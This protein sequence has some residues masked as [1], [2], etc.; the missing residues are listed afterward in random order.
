VT[1]SSIA[2]SRTQTISPAAAS[3]PST[4][5]RAVVSIDA[6][7]YTPEMPRP[8][9]AG[10]FGIAR[11]TRSNPPSQRAMSAIRVPAAIEST[12]APDACSS[13]ASDSHAIRIC[14]GLTARTTIVARASASDD[15]ASNS[16]TPR[17]RSARRVR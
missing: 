2:S 10:V 8:I 9:S 3:T 15:G 11:T 7:A 4:S 17:K 5:A 12:V 1:A 14:C 13:G 16:A 6:G